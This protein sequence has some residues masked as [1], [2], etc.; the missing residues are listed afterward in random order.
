MQFSDLLAELVPSVLW[1]S[2]GPQ[3]KP[4]GRT[5]GRVAAQLAQ[6]FLRAPAG[7]PRVQRPPAGR[8]AAPRPGLKPRPPKK[9]AGERWG[10][11]SALTM[12]PG[13]D[14]DSVNSR[15]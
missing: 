8:H 10:A 15:S 3:G 13:S 11:E 4:R 12:G 6:V 5:R 1:P 2:I 7:Q 9:N 14:S